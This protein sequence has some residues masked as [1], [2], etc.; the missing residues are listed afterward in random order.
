MESKEKIWIA[1]IGIKFDEL[2]G[3]CLVMRISLLIMRM[4]ISVQTGEEDNTEVDADLEGSPD[5]DSDENNL[6][7]IVLHCRQ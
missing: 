2:L 1:K 3:I 6:V 5:V 4:M 7:D